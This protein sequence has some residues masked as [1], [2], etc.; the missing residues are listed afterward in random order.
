MKEIK[1]YSNINSVVGFAGYKVPGKYA[2]Y[3]LKP[4]S[5]KNYLGCLARSKTAIYVRGLHNCLSFKFGQLLS[6]GMPIVGQTIKNNR[7][8]IMSN[9]Y[10]NEQFAYNNPKEI[11]Q[12][13]AKLLINPVKQ[14]ELSISNANIFD[15]KFSPRVIV[16]DILRQINF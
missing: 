14:K 7:D 3:Q 12:E 6:L 13:I 15:A 2:E 11:A 16:S 9:K 10:F 4:F 5:L 8:N 1:N